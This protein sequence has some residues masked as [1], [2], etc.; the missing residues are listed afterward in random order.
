MIESMSFYGI[1][2]SSNE[3]NFLLFSYLLIPLILTLLYSPFLSFFNPFLLL[4]TF[5][6]S[7]CL[8]AVVSHGLRR[9]NLTLALSCSLSL[10]RS[11][12]GV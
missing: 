2:A 11:F 9:E 5:L 12:C 8:F 1:L 6:S 3:L 4:Q 10:Q 7:F